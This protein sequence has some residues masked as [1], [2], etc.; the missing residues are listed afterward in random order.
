MQILQPFA[1]EVQLAELFQGTR[2]AVNEL[3][4]V[5]ISERERERESAWRRLGFFCRHMRHM[6]DSGRAAALSRPGGA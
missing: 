1:E 3:N 5:K 4:C 2:A 6:A